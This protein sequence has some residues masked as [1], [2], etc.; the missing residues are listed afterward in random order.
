M[1]AVQ[2]KAAPVAPVAADNRGEVDPIRFPRLAAL[3]AADEGGELLRELRRFQAYN[4]RAVR[5]RTVAVA[6][7]HSESVSAIAVIQD[8]SN[9]G[10]RVRVDQR[11]EGV[12]DH[13]VGLLVNDGNQRVVVP[14]EFE[15]VVERDGR[16]IDLAYKFS[17][18]SDDQ[19][20]LVDRLQGSGLFTE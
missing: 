4:P 8:M 13:E 11:H 3:V 2:A 17:R 9:S 15:R 14:I 20:Q 12:A 16:D 7:L 19:R 1:S 6:R 5:V 18:L 10:V